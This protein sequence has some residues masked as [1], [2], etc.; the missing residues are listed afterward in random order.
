MVVE[1]GS[2]SPV[3]VVVMV[4]NRIEVGKQG[5]AQLYTPTRGEGRHV[6]GGNRRNETPVVSPAT[7]TTCY[8]YCGQPGDGQNAVLFPAGPKH[9]LRHSKTSCAQRSKSCSNTTTKI[10]RKWYSLRL[11]RETNDIRQCTKSLCETRTLTPAGAQ[12]TTPRTCFFVHVPGIF[13]RRPAL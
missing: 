13:S 7:G 1:V 9:R 4:L 2:V 3:L 11:G 5:K 8:C 6:N 10:A 12:R